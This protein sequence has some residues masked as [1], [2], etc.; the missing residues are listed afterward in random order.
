MSDIDLNSDPRS[1]DFCL[2]ENNDDESDQLSQDEGFLEDDDLGFKEIVSEGTGKKAYQVDYVIHELSEIAEYQAKEAEHVANII[3]IAPQHAA[4]LLRYCHWNKELL[5]EKYMDHPDDLF[6]S[7]CVIMDTSLAPKIVSVQ[8]F[9]CSI[10]CEDHHDLNTLALSCGHRFC[11]PCY[12]QYLI[13][14]IQDEGESRRITCMGQCNL[15]VD[16]TTTQSLVPPP[17]F[18]KFVCVVVLYVCVCVCV[19]VFFSLF[20]FFQSVNI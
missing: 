19:C 12:R 16:A 13:Q 4:T 8:G 7:A 1:E 15:I 5:L 9:V 3:H 17:I 20:F 11:V 10:C 14:K 18:E 2:S 6:R